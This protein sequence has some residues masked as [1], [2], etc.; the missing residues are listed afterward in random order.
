MSVFVFTDWTCSISVCE[1]MEYLCSLVFTNKPWHD[2]GVCSMKLLVLHRNAKY[3]LQTVFTILLTN[4]YN[5]IEGKQ[6]H[7]CVCLDLQGTFARSV[8]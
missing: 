8:P 2:H 4:I 7:V 5:I 3:W 6:C 1:I